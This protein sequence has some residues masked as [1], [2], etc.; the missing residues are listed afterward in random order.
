[1]KGK[2]TR[3]ATRTAAKQGSRSN[4]V[5]MTTEESWISTE[6]Q[7]N[8]Q[9]VAP[10]AVV[11]Q[12]RA[13]LKGLLEAILF[14]ADRPL[15]LKELARAAKLDRKRTAELLDE[16]RADYAA[17]GFRIQEVAGG[18]VFR[19]HASYA[20]SVRNFLAQRPV[21]LSRAQ[22]ETL[23][24]V[25]YRQPITRPEID[26]VR[27]VDSGP[28]LKGLLE[29]DLVRILGKKDEPGR[30]MLYGTTPGFLEFF[31]LQ[32]LEQLPTLREFT[33]LTDD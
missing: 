9:A 5:D 19:T 20:D 10:G 8:A 1:M 6:A 24:I 27:G 4:G 18:V 3:P 33:E 22:L 30:P 28:V 31:G 16:L 13:Y 25:A 32:A 2:L 12:T 7:D 29:R 23:A 11:G 26:D 15:E 17:R 21:R 14:V